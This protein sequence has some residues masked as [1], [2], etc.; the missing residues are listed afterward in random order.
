MRLAWLVVFVGCGSTTTTMDGSVDGPVE[1]TTDSTV[2]APSACTVGK[3]CGNDCISPNEAP[4]WACGT[5]HYDK[6]CNC[7]A[8][9]D[10]GWPD[11][12][13]PGPVGEGEFC[14]TYWWCNRGCVQGLTCAPIPTD[15]GPGFDFRMT[16]QKPLADAGPG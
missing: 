11:C 2:D 14:G 7:R 9:P 8:T 10:M 13:K 3:E 5:L 1:A 16:C 6:D 12:T 15:A 4:F